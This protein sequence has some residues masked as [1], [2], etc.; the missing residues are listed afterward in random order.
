MPETPISINA[1]H[2]AGTKILEVSGRIDANS[3][4][5]LDSHLSKLVQQKAQRIL[6][7]IAGVD[8]ISSAGLRIF[9]A[10]AK[11]LNLTGGKISLCSM[12]F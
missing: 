8:Y 12:R 11:K 7:D 5:N 4:G 10:N 2:S 3:C 9:V 6:V 1:S